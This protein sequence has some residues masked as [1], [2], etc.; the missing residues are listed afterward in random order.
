MDDDNAIHNPA[1]RQSPRLALAAIIAVAAQM[2]GEPYEVKRVR[3]GGRPWVDLLSPSTE[4]SV[5]PCYLVGND[6]R[7]HFLAQWS[8][9]GTALTSHDTFGR[10]DVA[11]TRSY[12]TLA[13]SLS[14]GALRRAGDAATGWPVVIPSP[15][16]R[17]RL[18][19]E[20]R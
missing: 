12:A 7:G 8:K 1:P 9:P 14:T 16:A 3:F 13:T 18:Y 4:D 5:A 2:N 10:E 20:A 11:L 19:V 15:E 17:E 6:A